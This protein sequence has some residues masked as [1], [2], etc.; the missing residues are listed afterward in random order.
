MSPCEKKHASQGLCGRQMIPVL[1][2]EMP[3]PGLWCLQPE[4]KNP[5]GNQSHRQDAGADMQGHRE[6]MG[7]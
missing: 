1:E 3:Q 5:N 7:A 4:E 6:A 2:Q